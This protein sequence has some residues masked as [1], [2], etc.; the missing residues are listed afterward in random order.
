MAAILTFAPTRGVLTARTAWRMNRSNEGA[1]GREAQARPRLV[2]DRANRGPV[3]VCR[4]RRSADGRL[5]CHWDIEVPDAPN[6]S[7]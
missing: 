1:L 5:S 3:L 4:W 7:S 6:P 2:L